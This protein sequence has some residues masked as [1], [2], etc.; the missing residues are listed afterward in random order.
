VDE[1]STEE[2]PMPDA[3]ELRY[4]VAAVISRVTLSLLLG[5]GASVLLAAFL[6]VPLARAAGRIGE[7]TLLAAWGLFLALF[8][9]W[10]WWQSTSYVLRVDAVGIH[11]A[12]GLERTTVHWADVT[13]AEAIQPSPAAGREATEGLY[14]V[15]RSPGGEKLIS[16]GYDISRGL[17]PEQVAIF[18]KYVRAQLEAH[19]IRREGPPLAWINWG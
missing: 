10:V 19:D 14:V 6:Q 8:A 18:K 4:P 13:T 16:L 9:C 15:L 12:A 5:I 17:P 7:T 2:V 11:R 3:V 1:V